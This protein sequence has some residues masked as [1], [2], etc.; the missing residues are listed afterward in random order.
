[1]LLVLLDFI[2]WNYGRFLHCTLRTVRVLS[3]S[4]FSCHVKEKKTKQKLESGPRSYQ[5]FVI[6]YRV[7]SSIVTL[8]RFARVPSSS[9]PCDNHIVSQVVT[10]H[11]GYT[12]DA[13]EYI[14]VLYT[15]VKC[16]TCV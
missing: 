9:G 12:N 16:V 6:V 2:K 8:L 7:V 14:D 15:I 1:M 13:R 4:F 10:H 11:N 3:R 5:R